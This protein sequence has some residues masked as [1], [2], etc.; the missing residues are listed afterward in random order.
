[1]QNIT[2][3]AKVGFISLGCPKNQL[4][5]ELMISKASDAGFR[6]TTD[7]TDAEAIVINTC[8]FIIPAQQEA[9]EAI[10]EALEHKETGRCR[11]VVVAGCLPQYL[12]DRATGDYPGVDAWLTPDNPGDL[13]KVLATL[14]GNANGQS[15]DAG[16][17]TT[18]WE[19]PT[20]LADSA[21]GR[22]LTTPPSLAYVKIAEGCNHGCKFCIIPQLRGRYRSRGIDD[23]AAE[24]GGICE[25]ET[26]EVVLVSQDSSFYGR[27]LQDASLA[28]LVE[29]LCA[30]PGDFWLRVMYLYPTHV[31]DELLETW[32]K[33]APKLLPYFDVPVQHVSERLLKSMGRR[34]NR[35]EVD[36]LFDRI[37]GHCPDAVIRT[38][39]ITGYPGETEEDF[40]ELYDW[41]AGGAVDRLGVFTYSDL[42]EM[43][44]HSLPD[45]VDGDVAA[46]RQDMLMEAQYETLAKAQDKLIGTELDVVIEEPDEAEPHVWWGRSWREAYEIDGLVRVESK[47]E[48][49]LFRRVKVKVTGH[50]GYDLEAEAL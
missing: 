40:N 4:D 20:F 39:L 18:D 13:G 6:V 17:I 49:E 50:D 10:A 9:D 14:L 44:S 33:C 15:R 46:Q 48:L 43:R 24:V 23:I 12:K 3:T 7:I 37:R 21:S 28:R 22:V 8:A 26:P 34:G 1:M 5:C 42:P 25:M 2:R 47:L 36:A 11:A 35:A 32:A 30:V 41:I 45:H 38:S 19:L 27:D 16:A 29:K 31:T